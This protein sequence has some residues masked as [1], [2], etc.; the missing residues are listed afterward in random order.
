MKYIIISGS[1]RRV[2]QSAKVARYLIKE[3]EGKQVSASVDFLDLAQEEIPPWNERF[4]EEENPYPEWTHWSGRLRAADALIL[5]APE[6][7]GMVPPALSNL[8]LLLQDEVAHKPALIVSVSAGP[9]GSYPVAQLRSFAYKNHRLCFMPDHVIVRFVEQVLN[10]DVPEQED[11]RYIRD[12]IDYALA[13]LAVY[14]EAFR[15]IRSH[16]HID[17]QR[18]PHG[19]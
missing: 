3:I 15:N 18:H 16:P 14:V 4:W 1:T 6:W 7:N 11:D 8:F 12:R 5:V 10:D 9:N 19:M 2:G 17:L 13:V